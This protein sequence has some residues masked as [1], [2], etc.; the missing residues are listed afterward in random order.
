MHFLITAGL[1]KLHGFLILL[2]RETTNRSSFHWYL[3]IRERQKQIERGVTHISERKLKN[4][5][6]RDNIWVPTSS[7]E[8]HGGAEKME[9][10]WK[11]SG[12]FGPE[13]GIMIKKF[14]ESDYRRDFI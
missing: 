13:V 14:E 10:A 5:I 12:F 11:A 2:F 3:R 1:E 7:R 6:Q 8:C 4:I 9:N